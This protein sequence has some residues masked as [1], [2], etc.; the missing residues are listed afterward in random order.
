MNFIGG[1]VLKGGTVVQP[2]K[3]TFTIPEF[4]KHSVKKIGIR[5]IITV[6]F[7]FYGKF[8]IFA[9]KA[10]YY[11]FTQKLKKILKQ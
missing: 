11:F 3:G 7:S 10:R 6:F 2:Q 1:T 8:K 9:E 5:M 4:R